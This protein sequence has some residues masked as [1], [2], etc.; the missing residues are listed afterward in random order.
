MWVTDGELRMRDQCHQS[1]ERY[2]K[3]SFHNG[4]VLILEKHD[5]TDDDLTAV[6]RVGQLGRATH[7]EDNNLQVVALD[8]DILQVPVLAQIHGVEFTFS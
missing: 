3:K 8:V 7:G 6:H 1:R 5:A 4:R 2:Q